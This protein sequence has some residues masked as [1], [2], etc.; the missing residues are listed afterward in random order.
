MTDVLKCVIWDLDDTLWRGTLIEND[1]LRPV[2]QRFALLRELDG[3]GVLQ[4]VAS[5]GDQERA[6]QRLRAYG[7]FDLLV[8]PQI[9]WRDKSEAVGDIVSA[10]GF[11]PRTVAFVDNDPFERAEFRAPSGRFRTGRG[12]HRTGSGRSTPRGRSCSVAS[13]CGTCRRSRRRSPR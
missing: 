7:L 10:L 5:R 9:G 13:V 4:S 8:W 11:D 12:P 2:P 6:E 3:R 1:A